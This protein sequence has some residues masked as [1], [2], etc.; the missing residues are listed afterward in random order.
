M[1]DTAEESKSRATVVDVPEDANDTVI[2]MTS[3]VFT[4][5]AGSTAVGEATPVDVGSPKI[6]VNKAISRLVTD[7]QETL[8]AMD[9]DGDGE[10]SLP[11]FYF[12]C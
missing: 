9:A 2:E 4:G 12:C 3:R 1:A 11:S 5:T 7:A 8:L 10:L 6:S